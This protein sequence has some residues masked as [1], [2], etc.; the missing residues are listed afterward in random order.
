M[1]KGGLTLTDSQA[2]LLPK[3][4]AFLEGPDR[5]FLL[6]GKPGVGKTTM[7]RIVLDKYIQA[8][9]N[10]QHEKG[11]QNVA[12]IAMA[13][14]AK[15]VLGEH[16]PYVYTFASAYGLKEK[17]D[18]HTGK[19]SF[20][21]DPNFKGELVGRKSIP[22]FVHDEVSMYTQEM[23]DIVM[24]NLSSFS[25]VI[26]MGDSAQLPPIIDDDSVEKDEDSPIF[27]MDFPEHCRH[28]LTERVRQ[29]E[30][31]P[32]L[33]LSDVMRE[34]IFG[35]HLINPVIE[36]MR[37]SSVVDG[38]GFQSVRYKDLLDHISQKDIMQTRIL[39]YRNKAIN[40]FNPE[41]RNHLLN[42]PK[43][44]IVEGDVIIMKENF[45]YDDKANGNKFVIQNSES[46][47]IKNVQPFI[48]R[49][50]VDGQK[51]KFD[52]Y[53]ARI[54][55]ERKDRLFIVP[56][57]EGQQQFDYVLQQVA[58][59]C[60]KRLVSWEEFWNMKKIFCEFTYGYASSIHKAQG[61][62]FKDV[63]VDVNDI[64]MTGP[65]TDKV[66]LQAIYT[67]ITRARENVYFLKS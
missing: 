47:R 7:T 49:H 56:T 19:R 62:G 31:N 51:Y 48:A 43:D 37:N 65:I 18:D 13:H 52:A 25:K 32:I 59:K 26:F 1:K 46:F 5:A 15:N 61:S 67:A 66:K 10:G 33:E 6:I 36:A 12:G 4:E 11:T 23:L 41:V 35:D 58:D 60:R 57:Y 9:R 20:V 17:Y 40:W 64:L 2:E 45:Y 3:M 8:D 34:Q 44:R 42:N 14:Q 21:Y 29:A 55:E 28:E 53:V 27:R 16:I 39:A 50:T 63:Y 38:V 54:E 24:D 30:G 22:V